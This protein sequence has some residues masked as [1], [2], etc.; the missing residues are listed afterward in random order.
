MGVNNNDDLRLSVETTAPTTLHIVAPTNTAIPCVAIATNITQLLFGG[1]LP[2][3]PLTA[4]VAYATPSGNPDDAC[5]ISTN[6]SLAGKIALLDRGSTNCASVTGAYS[7]YAAHQAQLAGAVAVIE[8]TPGDT[9]FPFRLGDNDPSVTVPVLVIGD[10]FGGGWLKSLLTNGVA[11]TATIQE[12]PA[13]RIA[14]WNGPKGFGSVDSLAGFAVPAAGLYPM[15]LVA[16]HSSGGADLEWFS[17]LP[18]GTR[19]LLNDASNTNALLAYQA[20]AIVDNFPMMNPPILANGSITLSW[21]GGVLQE[22]SSI[23]GQWSD[24]ANQTNPQTIPASGPM[25]FYRIRGQ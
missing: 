17:I 14:D 21:R 12:D 22:A 10:S 23:G 18:D 15:R 19:V 7:A 25:K 13:P 5:F 24:S 3:T 16:G 8:T 4:P 2:L 20:V 9:G 1:A 6:S 11:V